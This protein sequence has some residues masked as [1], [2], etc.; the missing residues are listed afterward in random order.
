MASV[1][2]IISVALTI[3]LANNEKGTTLPQNMQAQIKQIKA[4]VATG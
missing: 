3:L 2:K 1:N 4:A